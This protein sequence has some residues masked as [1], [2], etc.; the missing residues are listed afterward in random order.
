MRR[1]G[2]GAGVAWGLDGVA[3]CVLRVKCYP[4]PKAPS[5]TVWPSGLRRWLQ[6]PVRKGV[7]SNPTAVT[8][9]NHT[10]PAPEPGPSDIFNGRQAMAEI[11]GTLRSCIPAVD[12]LPYAFTT[13]SLAEWSKALASGASP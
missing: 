7:D 10:A 2:A 13:D 11:Y 9:P 4:P 5:M 12:T 3:V 6:A 1:C 8:S